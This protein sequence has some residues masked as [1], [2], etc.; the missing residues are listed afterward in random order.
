MSQPTK[1]GASGITDKNNKHRAGRLN[2]C[3]LPETAMVLRVPSC[4]R[5]GRPQ[6]PV[7]WLSV[8]GES[9]PRRTFWG[10]RSFRQTMSEA[11]LPLS[12]WSRLLSLWGQDR[13]ND[14]CRASINMPLFSYALVHHE[15]RYELFVP[16]RIIA[17]YIHYI[18]IHI[19]YRY[20]LISPCPNV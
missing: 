8:F 10:A 15:I 2:R 18:Y 17:H 11:V 7:N 4:R 13:S 20:F 9:L 5:D 12:G 16:S 3:I 6:Q 1:R 14:L 19:Y